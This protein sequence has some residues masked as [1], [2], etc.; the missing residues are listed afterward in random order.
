MKTDKEKKVDKYYVISFGNSD[1]Y[2]LHDSK[3]GK[4][5][6]LTRIENE[7]NEYLQQKF[8]NETFAYFT[9]PRVDEIS[10]EHAKEYEKYPLLDSRAVES[11]KH[12][13]AREVENME[14][15]DRL[16][17]NAPYAQVNPGAAGVNIYA[18]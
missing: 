15:N 11:I 18:P 8:P 7:L 4:E 1:K 13:L 16:D 5:S 9:S 14:A 2:F 17:R 3:V 12:V 10:P 6:R